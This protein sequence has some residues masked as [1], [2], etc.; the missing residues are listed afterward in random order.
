MSPAIPVAL[1]AALFFALGNLFQK[2]GL[3]RGASR[4]PKGF[5]AWCAL[6]LRDPRWL[7]GIGCSC[8]GALLQYAAMA[9]WNLSVVQP[10]VAL[11]PPVTALLCRAFLGE[12]AP[13]GL[14][15][16]LAL[17]LAGVALM[18]LSGEEAAGAPRAAVWPA[19]GILCAL[20][21]GLWAAGRRASPERAERLLAL[22]AGAGFGLSVLLFKLAWLDLS[23]AAA[24]GSLS[25][26]AGAAATSAALWLYVA[27]YGGAFLASQ[28]ALAKGR[29][30]LV[31]PL[32]AA[33][34]NLVPVLGGIFLFG[35]PCGAFKGGAV[36]L[37]CASLLVFFAGGRRAAREEARSV[38]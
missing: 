19:V 21:A 38:G 24:S 3:D 2:K 1:S 18:G 36:A 15:G 31:V 32:S 22:S 27:V 10:L 23:G 17:A 20:A 16:A 5:K 28:T 30:M 14:W 6:L 4:S 8:A 26:A 29:G 35:E 9:N 37:L 33:V 25:D 11:N 34:G 13:R 12:R 7:G